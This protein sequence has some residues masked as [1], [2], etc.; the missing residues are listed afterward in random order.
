MNHFL[1]QM[2][3]RIESVGRVERPGYS[4]IGSGAILVIGMR[5][6]FA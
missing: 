3:A 2:H 1:F 4:E 5:M 6:A